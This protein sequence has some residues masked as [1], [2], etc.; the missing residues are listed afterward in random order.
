MVYYRQEF[1]NKS[2]VFPFARFNFFRGGYKAERNAPY[3]DV[4]EWEMGLEWQLT[5][6]IELTTQYT[7][8]D[9]TN[10]VA[11]SVGRSYGQY[12]G[13]LLRTQL[14]INY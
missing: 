8:S 3:S 10:T 9:R 7:I 6:Q 11:Q 1:E 4:K 12:E 14:Q 5:P 13:H 2:V